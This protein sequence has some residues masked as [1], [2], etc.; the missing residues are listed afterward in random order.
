MDFLNLEVEC[1]EKSVLN[2]SDFDKYKFQLICIETEHDSEAI[3]LAEQIIVPLLII[4]ELTR[5]SGM[6]MQIQMLCLSPKP[7]VS[8][9]LKHEFLQNNRP[10]NYPNISK[11]AGYFSNLPQN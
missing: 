8:S 7:G 6:S 5:Y 1:A 3:R 2:E 10:E 4:W 11:A 9:N